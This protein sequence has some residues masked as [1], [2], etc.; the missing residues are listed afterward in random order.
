MSSIKQ[1]NISEISKILENN[2]QKYGPRNTALILGG[3]Y[4]GL[5]PLELC[6][7]SVEDVMAPNGQFYEV[8]VLPKHASYNGEPREIQT[9]DHVLNF[10][11]DYI[12][13]L[14][15][16]EW[17]LCNLSSHRG[18][19]PKGQFFLNDSGRPYKLTKSERTNGK[20][21]YQA[22][23]MND[24][25]KRMIEKTDIQDAKPSS[26]RD[27]YIRFLWDAGCNWNE[28]KLATGIKSKKTLES[29]IRP[30]IRELEQVYKRLCIGIKVPQYNSV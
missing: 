16:N 22:R 5:T 1:F 12:S 18:L 29:K 27:T 25:L 7:I 17:G 21:S 30:E 2:A 3:V 10:F 9:R 15:A 13:F 26:F 24:H 4:W 14:L 20:I 28:L 11:E 6:K 8:W 19:N 23:S